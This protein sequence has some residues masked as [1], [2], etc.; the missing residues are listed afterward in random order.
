MSINLRLYADQ[1]YG[2][3]KSYMS[4]YLSPEIV[5]EEFINNF[6]SG[7]LKYETISTKKSIKL[8]FQ[9]NL[10]ELKIQNF[11][12]NIPNETENL[13]LYIGKMKAILDLNEINDEEIESIILNERKSLIEG[14]INFVIKKIEK[15]SESKSFIEG[16]METFINRAINGLKIDLNN[17]ELNIKFKKYIFYFE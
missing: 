6:K 10:S 8:N 7:K 16:L 5:K 14:F 17:I 9:V 1:I 12:L 13:S 4:E 2:F 11:E 15:K 3:G